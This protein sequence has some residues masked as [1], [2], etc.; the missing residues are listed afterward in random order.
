[1]EKKQ[2][3]ME[4]NTAN[5]NWFDF[6]CPRANSVQRLSFWTSVSLDI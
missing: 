3:V 2:S 5:E 4:R 6:L 1:M